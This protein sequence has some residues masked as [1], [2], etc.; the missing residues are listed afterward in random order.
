MQY[1]GGY[2]NKANGTY[3]YH[4]YTQTDQYKNSYCL[5]EERKTQTYEYRTCSIKMIREC[6]TQMSFVW[7]Y[8]DRVQDKEITPTEYFTSVK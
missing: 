7:L 6:G 3:Y 4:A 5:K 8:I 1:Y 2:V